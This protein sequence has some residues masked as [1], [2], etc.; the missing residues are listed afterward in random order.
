MKIVAVSSFTAASLALSLVAAS[1]SLLAFDGGAQV[2]AKT[3]GATITGKITFDGKRPEPKPLTATPEQQKG[4]C[5]EGKS[6]NVTDPTFLID[7]KGGIANVL[8]TIEAGGAEL[9]VPKDPIVLDQR[10]CVFEPHCTIAPAGAKVAF[11]NSDNVSHN[12][13]IYAAKNDSFNDTIAAGARKEV[14]FQKAEKIQVKC[15]IHPWMSSYLFV[16]DT[17]YAAL[18]KADGT[19]SLTG[20]KP[21]TYKVKLWHETLGRGEAQAVVKDDGTCAPIEVKMA[22]PKKKG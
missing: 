14:V 15:D 5:P 16:V 19:F 4:C 17:P 18:T 22:E 11:L 13:H 3:E 9:V 6:V 12:V 8:V 1:S 10:Q 20:L 21:G 7:E 2:A